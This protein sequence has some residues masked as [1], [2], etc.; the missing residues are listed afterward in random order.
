MKVEAFP[1]PAGPATPLSNISKQIS[2]Q[3]ANETTKKEQARE[4][5][6]DVSD[7]VS[8][9]ITISR[10]TLDT[11]ERIGGISDILNSTAKNIRETDKNLTLSADI[12]AKMKADLEKIVKNYPPFSMESEERRTILMSYDALKKQIDQ[13]TVP[14]PPPPIYE[15]IS[16]IWQDLFPGQER[17]VST[18][19]VPLSA[20]D[21]T[22]QSAV[23][24]LT[25]ADNRITEV[26]NE[27]G[28]AFA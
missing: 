24:S 21:S 20:S 10:R 4:S 18:P 23:D 19:T 6:G 1:Q 16:H 2:E 8:L 9:S 14:P 28:T 11:L 13:L 3:H 17:S 22:V 5:V 27:L 15:K 25:T 7:H 26:R 12:I